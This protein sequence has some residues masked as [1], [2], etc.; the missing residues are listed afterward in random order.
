MNT[1]MMDEIVSLCSHD[2]L[3][4]VSDDNLGFIF[5]KRNETGYSKLWR[6]FAGRQFTDHAWMRSI[7]VT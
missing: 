3:L 4:H 6:L 7:C 1:G 2:R 5:R